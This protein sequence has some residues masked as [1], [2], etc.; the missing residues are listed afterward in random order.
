MTCSSSTWQLRAIFV[1]V[2]WSSSRSQRQAILQLLEGL[3]VWRRDTYHVGNE[4]GA[5]DLSNSVLSGLCLLLSVDNGN[6][7]NTDAQEVVAAKSVAE[8]LGVVSFTS[9]SEERLSYREG[10]DEGTRLEI[11]NCAT[12][13]SVS[14]HR[15][16]QSRS[17]WAYQLNYHKSVF[18][19]VSNLRMTY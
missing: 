5:S 19:P 12:L 16:C 18:R 13:V 2:A 14:V 7:R 4:T 17:V 15:F 3:D 10:L 11:T 1:M 6:V 9:S 8:L